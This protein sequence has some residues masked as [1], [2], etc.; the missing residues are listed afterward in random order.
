[1]FLGKIIIQEPEMIISKTKK[2]KLNLALRSDRPKLE[3]KNVGEV[4]V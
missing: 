2:N 3:S 4:L 1:M